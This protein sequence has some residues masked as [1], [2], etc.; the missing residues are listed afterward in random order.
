MKNAQTI[1]IVLLMITAIALG[2]ILVGSYTASPAYA[3]QSKGGDYLMNTV[4]FSDSTDLVCVIDMGTRR[5]NT[6]RTNITNE[7]I[8]LIDDT[9]DLE[10]SFTD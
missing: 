8:D 6:Y 10:K 1:T 9:V 3:E 2:A 7:S 4:A 5:M